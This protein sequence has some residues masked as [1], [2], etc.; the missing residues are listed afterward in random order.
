MDQ[1]SESPPALLL[2]NLGTPDAPTASAVRRYLVEFECSDRPEGLVAIVPPAADTVNPFES[3][4]CALAAE[5][6]IRCE[7]S[8]KP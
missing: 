3:M 7:L 8:V 2:V 1:A 5:R 4:N 6:G